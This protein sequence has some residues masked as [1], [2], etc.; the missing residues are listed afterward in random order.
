MSLVPP[1]QQLGELRASYAPARTPT[2]AVVGMWV[3]IVLMTAL[4]VTIPFAIWFLVLLLRTPNYSATARAKRVDLYREG[5][6]LV[7]AGGPVAVFRFD[8]MSLVQKIVQRRVNGVSTGTT[9]DFTLTDA[10]G[11][12]RRITGFYERIDELGQ[13]LQGGVVEAQLHGAVNAVL[14]GQAVP[15]GDFTLRREGIDCPKGLVPWDRF[16]GLNLRSGTVFLRV[17]DKR[18][19]FFS[20]QV[21][22]VPNLHL[23]LRS[24]ERLRPQR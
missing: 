7:E 13:A 16:A 17:A 11:D 10:Q 14:A 1:P 23:F 4:V 20:R 6:V 3:M 21:A 24:V 18:T 15:F 19:A 8:R 12:S 22:R 5:V 9:Y 2:A